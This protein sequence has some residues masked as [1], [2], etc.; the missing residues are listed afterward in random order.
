MTKDELDHAAHVARV[1][2]VLGRYCVRLVDESDPRSTTHRTVPL[3]EVER[4]LGHELV[5]LGQ[6]LLGRATGR[7]HITVP[8]LLPGTYE[9]APSRS[10]HPTD[11]TDEPAQCSLTEGTAMHNHHEPGPADDLPNPPAS[12]RTLASQRAPRL[13]A[14]GYAG[15]DHDDVGIA[16]WGIAFPDQVQVTSTDGTHQVVTDRPEHAIRHF[17]EAD[18]TMHMI[19]LEVR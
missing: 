7:G 18:A 11:S 19:E 4:N 2:T 5:E 16:A 10:T 1:N 12:L 13:F 17:L 6:A 15:G 14:I 8:I 9:P 3:E